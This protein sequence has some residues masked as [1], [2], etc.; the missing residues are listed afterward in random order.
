MSYMM[1]NKLVTNLW[2]DTFLWNKSYTIL[3]MCN[4]DEIKGH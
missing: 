1:M 4:R 2:S 3:Q